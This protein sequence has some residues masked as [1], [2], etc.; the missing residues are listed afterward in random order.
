MLTEEMKAEQRGY[1]RAI[2]E[3]AKICRDR[4]AMYRAKAKKR[5]AFEDDT[6]NEHDR[7][8]GYAEA[9]EYAATAIEAGEHKP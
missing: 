3:A 6:L 2:A 1:D 9:V 7:F 4:A 5:N 8:M